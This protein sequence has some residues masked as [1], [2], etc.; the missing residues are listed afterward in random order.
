M[1]HQFATKIP[2]TTDE[3]ELRTRNED[4]DVGGA[5]NVFVCN[6]VRIEYCNTAE[7]KARTILRV[8]LPPVDYASAQANMP[9]LHMEEQMLNGRPSFVRNANLNT[10]RKKAEI[11]LF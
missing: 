1:P 4:I 11:G 7:L 3:N 8:Q 5:F 6:I 10:K 9:H 2:E